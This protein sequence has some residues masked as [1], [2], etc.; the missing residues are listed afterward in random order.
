MPVAKAVEFWGPC[1]W[2]FLHSIAFSYTDTPSDDQVAH[3]T[4]FFEGLPA[5]IPCPSC[6]EHAR[7]YFIQ[8]EGELKAAIKAGGSALQRFLFN[9]HNDV[10]A[11]RGVPPM[12]FETVSA[13]YTQG[14]APGRSFPTSEKELADPHHDM[15]PWA[16]TSVVNSAGRRGLSKQEVGIGVALLLIGGGLWML[17]QRRSP[18]PPIKGRRR[19]AAAAATTT[20]PPQSSN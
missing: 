3:F 11:R 5:V 12:P 4:S 18:P 20:A 15:L 19:P 2:K 8:H 14:H 7:E 9:F 13:I 16:A 1:A 10:N 6:G 17:L